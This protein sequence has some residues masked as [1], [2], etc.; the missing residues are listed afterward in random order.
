ME[1]EDFTFLFDIILENF[2]TDNIFWVFYVLNFIF[3]AIAYQL[4][5]ARKLSSIKTVFVYIVLA[6]GTYIITIFS[7]FNL[8]ITESLI[9]VAIILAIY[10]FRMYKQRKSN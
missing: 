5:F 3:A 1:N 7:I 6:I 9:V 4:G 10:R 8:P 2:G